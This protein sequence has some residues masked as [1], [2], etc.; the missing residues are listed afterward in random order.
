MIQYYAIT[1]E[2]NDPEPIVKKI[3]PSEAIIQK[4]EERPIF[5]GKRNSSKYPVFVVKANS[6]L[7]ALQLYEDFIHIPTTKRERLN[8]LNG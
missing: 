5:T 7:D 4:L 1:H 8:G 2:P 3:S 6:K